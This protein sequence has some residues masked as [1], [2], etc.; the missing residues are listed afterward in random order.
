M[1]LNINGGKQYIHDFN[2]DLPNKSFPIKIPIKGKNIM[3]NKQVNYGEYSLK[4]NAFNPDNSSPPNSWNKR[5]M[6]RL[7]NYHK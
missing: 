5:L 2:K 3:N 7:S 1:F 4:G 6:S